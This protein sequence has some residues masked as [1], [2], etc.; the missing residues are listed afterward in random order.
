MNRPFVVGLTGGS[1]S[2]KTLFLKKLLEA[3]EPSN[4]CL[5][6]QDNYYRN[7][8]EVPQDKNGVHNFDDP[9]ALNF[10][11]FE[12]DLKAL[13]AG[14]T[15][16]RKEYTFNN[17]SIVPKMLTFKPAPIILVEGIFIFYSEVI[18]DLVDFKLFVEARESVKI[19]RRIA[20]DAIERGYDM[21]DVLYRYEHHVSPA[22]EKIIAP[23]KEIADLIIVNNHG[24]DM[25]FQAVSLFLHKQI[26]QAS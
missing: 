24:F 2:G 8:S 23:F 9:R 5:L 11:A 20:R 26:E 15:V 25:A 3:F 19:R 21:N 18:L 7:I 4:V 22:Y 16:T 17:S 10:D 1:A 12:A 6:G 14:E 13:I